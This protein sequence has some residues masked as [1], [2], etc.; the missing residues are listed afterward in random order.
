[1]RVAKRF[2]VFQ[3]F[4]NTKHFLAQLAAQRKVPAHHAKMNHADQG[5]EVRKGTYPAASAEFECARGGA[6]GFRRSEAAIGP[7]WVDRGELQ[8]EFLFVTRFILRQFLEDPDA[9][10]EMG[11][12]F[13][14]G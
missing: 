9:S 14:V 6:L 12:R 2:G 10:A 7:E 1:M 4:G 8:H 3:A 11:D 5:P 13:E